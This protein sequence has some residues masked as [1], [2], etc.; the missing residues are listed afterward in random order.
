MFQILKLIKKKEVPVRFYLGCYTTH[1]HRGKFFSVILLIS[2][3]NHQIWNPETLS[4]DMHFIKNIKSFYYKRLIHFVKWHLTPP[5]KAEEPAKTFKVPFPWKRIVGFQNG[6]HRMNF[7]GFKLSNYIYS[8]LWW[9]LKYVIEEKK[10][11]KRVPNEKKECQVAY[12]WAGDTY[13]VK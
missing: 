2:Q 5:T 3:N 13:G 1:S 4:D 9:L 10:K 8:K 12:R 11:K 7:W 6:L